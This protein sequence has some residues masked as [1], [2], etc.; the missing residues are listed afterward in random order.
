MSVRRHF[1]L[2]QKLECSN[3]AGDCKWD[4]KK[5]DDLPICISCIVD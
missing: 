3:D 2:T 4:I 1:A 5:G